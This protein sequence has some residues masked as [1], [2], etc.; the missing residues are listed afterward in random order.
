MVQILVVAHPSQ[1]TFIL[2]LRRVQYIFVCFN[3]RC[4]KMKGRVSRRKTTA[5]LLSQMDKIPAEV[6]VKY[7][8]S[9]PFL[10]KFNENLH[11]YIYELTLN[12]EP[13]N[14][15][16]EKIQWIDDFLNQL[17]DKLCSVRLTVYENHRGFFQHY[18]LHAVISKYNPN[19]SSSHWNRKQS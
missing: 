5:L 12:H 18:H 13:M 10:M 9:S 11:L 14:R 17:L 6:W 2:F 8:P 4:H 15:D 3:Q 7:D 19:V 1:S 16:F